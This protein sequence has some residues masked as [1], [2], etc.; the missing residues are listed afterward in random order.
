MEEGTFPHFRSLESDYEMEE[1]RRLCYVGMTRAEEKL[2]L[3]YANRRF[4]Y[5]ETYSKIPSRFLEEIPEEYIENPSKKETI[6]VSS[7]FNSRPAKP[8]PRNDY[9][10]GDKVSHKKWG[11]G[12]VVEV[13]PGDT[14]IKVAF[15]N[16]GIKS[17]DISFAPLEVI[18]KK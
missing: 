18:S 8:L 9:Q 13:K 3:S 15:P 14:V 10:L 7:F 17:L 12:V 2:F 6:S 16:Q 1:E 5:G 11:Q 4:I